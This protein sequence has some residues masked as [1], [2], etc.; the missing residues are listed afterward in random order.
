MN[1]CDFHE[2]AELL[3]N[4]HEEAHIRTSVGRAYY[5]TFLYFR[6]FLAQNGLEK[7]KPRHDIHAFVTECL[8][9]CNVPEGTKAAV[10]LKTLFKWRTDADYDLS[11]SFTVADSSD[12]LAEAKK[13]VSVFDAITIEKKNN[14]IKN[15]TDYAH[16]KAW[17]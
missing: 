11:K 17:I 5:G 7:M 4:H 9:F 3:K 14:I 15:A 16:R 13:I 12:R 6:E 1:P 10:R 2:T 8:Q